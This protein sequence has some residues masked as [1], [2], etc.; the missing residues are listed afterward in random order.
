MIKCLVTAEVIKEKL[1]K[2]KEIDFKYAGYNINHEVLNRNEL[3]KLI[4][5][6]EILICEYDTIDKE[7]LDC[8]DN[9]KLIICCRGGYKSV[10]DVD[11]AYEK[12]IMVCN[13]AG[14]NAD[15]VADLIMGYILD[16]TRNISKTNNLIHNKIITMDESTK[17]NE[18]K[19]TVWG[20]D[21]DS[22]FIRY[23]GSSINHMTLGIIGLGKVGQAVAKRALAFD[24][25]VIAHDPYIKENIPCVEIMSLN[26]LLQISDIISVNCAQTKDNKGMFNKELFSKM[27]KGSIFINTSRGSLVNEEDLV[28]YLK[29]GHLCAA[30]L[31]VTTVEPISSNSILLEP[32]N[33]ILTPHI[34]GSSYD[35]Q[36]V[37]TE[38]ICSMLDSYLKNEEPMCCVVRKREK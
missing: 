15:A 30:A 10:I 11:T 21:N 8:A 2:Y 38:M 19:D 6:I 23:R 32:D 1:D 5:D 35:V 36:Y 37:G 33:L 26:S 14:R 22:P 7:I 27:K 24:M 12:N 31:D 16:I 25:N 34:G 29:N 3:K 18:Y 13:M 17:P 9:L 28:E 20:L 4:K